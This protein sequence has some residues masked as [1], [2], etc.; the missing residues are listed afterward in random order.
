MIFLPE[1]QLPVIPRSIAVCPIC[2]AD[3]IL[4]CDEWEYDEKDNSLILPSECG[5][6]VNCTREPD[7]ED[8]PKKWDRWHRRH[9]DTPYADGWFEIQADVYEW[10]KANYRFTKTAQHW[11]GKLKA[12]VSGT[13]INGGGVW[14]MKSIKVT[15]ELQVA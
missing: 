4:D 5:L 15:Y 2:E 6:H 3:L 13:P 8:N 1:D 14:G 7:I 11:Q 10:V 12:W 9:W